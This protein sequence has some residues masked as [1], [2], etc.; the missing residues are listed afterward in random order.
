MITYIPGFVR[1]G[2]IYLKAAKNSM[3]KGP[4]YAKNEIERLQRLLDKVI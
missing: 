1:H 3:A 4:D 2:K